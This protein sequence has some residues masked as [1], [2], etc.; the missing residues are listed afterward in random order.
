MMKKVVIVQSNYLPWKGYF[1]L[2]AAAD[3][4]ILYDDMQYTKRDWRKRNR[5]KTPQGLQWITVPV[6][7]KGKYFQTIR[8]TEIDG[9]DWPQTHWRTLIA[10]YRRAPYFKDISA[11]LEP[12][13]FN[14]VHT[15]LSALNRA[16]LEIVCD[17]LHIQT[18]ISNSWD[19][20]L[21][22]GRSERLADLC[23]Q[24]GGRE[25][26]SGPAAKDYI[27]EQVFADRSIKLTWFDYSGYPEY[28]QLWGAF[29][30]EVSIVDLL[31]NCGPNAAQYLKRAPSLAS[32]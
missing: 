16:L 29:V 28:P 12:F 6:R 4:V 24:A 22:D 32:M 8:Q 9:G 21:V 30:H 27:V 13:F 25:Y 23:V 7:V 10:N 14:C 3:E 5:I 19:Y 20:S 2:I 31:Y 18:K 1:D 15:S 11:I 17:Y 26:I